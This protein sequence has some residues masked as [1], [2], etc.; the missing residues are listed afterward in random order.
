ME[1]DIVKKDKILHQLKKISQLDVELF[2]AYEG[3]RISDE[4]LYEL[5]Y[6]NFKK[7]YGNMGTLPAFG[8]ALSHYMLYKKI[9]EQDSHALI[10]ED[11]A[12]LANDF[13]NKLPYVIDFMAINED[14]PMV[15]LLS[16]HFYYNNKDIISIANK[17]LYVT[18]VQNGYMTSG[19]IINVKGAQ[20]LTNNLLPIRY[21]ADEWTKFTE[22]GLKVYGILP[23][24]TS[25]PD[26]MGEIG[27]SQLLVTETRLQKIRHV[28]GRIK[29]RIYYCYKY[30]SGVR[31][32]K[33]EW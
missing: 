25:F 21:L 4:K 24:M 7:R 12:I 1:K 9:A 15:V 11:D 13:S 10:L 27:K 16:P 6:Y 8:C 18:K 17:S 19:Y 5:G 29:G 2:N 22:M 30:I 28:L 14:S 31:Y 26:G 20:L 33:K 23:H 32:S 3:R